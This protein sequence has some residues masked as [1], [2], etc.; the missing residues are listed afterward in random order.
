MSI[1]CLSYS[2][3]RR[4]S[5]DRHLHVMAARDMKAAIAIARGLGAVGEMSVGDLDDCD[6]V[7]SAFMGRVLTDADIADMEATMGAPTRRKGRR[8]QTLR[9]RRSYAVRKFH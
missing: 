5:N 3:D 2:G 9:P 6:P 1:F 7:P 8:R 4:P